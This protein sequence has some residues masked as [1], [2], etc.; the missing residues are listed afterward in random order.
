MGS[1]R[2]GGGT[3][4]GAGVGA[5]GVVAGA[6]VDGV[7]GVDAASVAVGAGAAGEA[8]PTATWATF[9]AG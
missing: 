7:D 5:T 2:G 6:V 8:G 4:V 3:E 9:A 1:E